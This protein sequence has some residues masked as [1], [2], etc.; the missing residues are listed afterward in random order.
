VLSPSG[1]R[2]ADIVRGLKGV[3]LDTEGQ[4][5]KKAE[6]NKPPGEVAK[7]SLTKLRYS[8]RITSFIHSL[9]FL[10]LFAKHFKV[11]EQIE[12]LEKTKIWAAAGTPARIAKI[13]ADSGMSGHK[14]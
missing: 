3:T 1:I 4:E 12:H 7:V 8:L 11:S 14:A 2:A 9:D 6:Q 13:L 5:G 10:Q